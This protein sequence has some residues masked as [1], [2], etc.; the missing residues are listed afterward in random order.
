[1]D[2]FYGDIHGRVVTEEHLAARQ[3]WGDF[4]VAD[5]GFINFWGCA[6]GDRFE[7]EWDIVC[8]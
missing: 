8:G 2:N 7:T 4:M 3:Q 6:A 1:M 5:V